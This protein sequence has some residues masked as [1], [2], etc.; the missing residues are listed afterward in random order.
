MKWKLLNILNMDQYL[1]ANMKWSFDICNQM[2]SEHNFTCIFNQRNPPTPSHSDSHP[3]ISPPLG[4][5]KW[6][7]IIVLKRRFGLAFCFLSMFGT[8][9]CFSSISLLFNGSKRL[10]YGIDRLLMACIG[11]SMALS[12]S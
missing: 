5:H 8:F 9:C 6:F 3:C 12:V 11:L 2:S 10:I 7:Q 1:Q 4:G